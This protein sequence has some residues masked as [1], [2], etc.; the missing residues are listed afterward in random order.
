MILLIVLI[1]T[2]TAEFKYNQT[3]PTKVLM[4]LTIKKKKKKYNDFSWDNYMGNL[5]AH[6]IKTESIYVIY[7]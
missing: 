3:L 7:S 5:T 1:K 6:W 4:K 2:V